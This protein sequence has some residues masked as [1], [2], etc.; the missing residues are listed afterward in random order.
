MVS[1]Q[2]G[3]FVDRADRRKKVVWGIGATITA[4]AILGAL[5]VSHK[6]PF[7]PAKPAADTPGWFR[8]SDHGLSF[9]L[10]PGTLINPNTCPVDGTAYVLTTNHSCKSVV[11]GPA[12]SAPIVIWMHAAPTPRLR[13]SGPGSGVLRTIDSSGLSGFVIPMNDP[14]FLPQTQ[15]STYTWHLV[16]ARSHLEIDIFGNQKSVADK[17]IASMQLVL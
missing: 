7:G 15:G 17:V 8:V 2:E 13:P 1:S 9:A 11:V 12:H 10:P 4:V 3:E 14:G 6:L 16:E 5:F